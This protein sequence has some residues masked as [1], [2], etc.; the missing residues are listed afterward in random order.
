MKNI[1]KAIY[2]VFLVLM[3]FN[4]NGCAT[5]AL[6]QTEHGS[7]PSVQTKVAGTAKGIFKPCEGITDK[8]YIKYILINNDSASS[9]SFPLYENGY[10]Y[11]S[12]CS[13]IKKALA[14]VRRYNSHKI[15]HAKIGVIDVLN[16]DN[17][18]KFYVDLTVNR[19]EKMIERFHYPYKYDPRISEINFYH[20][21]EIDE[22]VLCNQFGKNYS[23]FDLTFMHETMS[24][25]KNKFHPAVVVIGTPFTV[26]F[27]VVT[28]PIQLILFLVML[29]I[30]PPA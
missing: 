25:D 8:Y 6:Y 24:I 21:S 4:V 9:S 10:V 26:A 14:D 29:S 16:A 2:Y 30:A 11:I 13:S 23:E 20:L 3:V 28:S 5:S 17:N 19:N 1:K 22:S 12:N 18:Q 27:D 15:S 7:L